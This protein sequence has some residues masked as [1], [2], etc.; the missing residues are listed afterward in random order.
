MCYLFVVNHIKMYLPKIALMADVD[1]LV[2]A[3]ALAYQELAKI[4]NFRLL[5]HIV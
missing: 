5:V 2:A 3:L 4:L 1:G